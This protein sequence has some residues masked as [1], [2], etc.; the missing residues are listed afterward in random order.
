VGLT[1]SIFHISA[2]NEL[3][4]AQHMALKGTFFDHKRI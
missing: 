1:P 2:I 4:D 3:L